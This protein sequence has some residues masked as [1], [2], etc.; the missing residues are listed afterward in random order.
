MEN[1]NKQKALDYLL[2]AINET[3]RNLPKGNHIIALKLID[4]KDCRDMFGRKLY[5]GE[6]VRVVW[7]DD[8]DRDDGYYDIYVGGDNAMGVLVDTFKWLMRKL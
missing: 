3:N 6:Y 8:P 4:R 5:D 7:S 2:M 1:E